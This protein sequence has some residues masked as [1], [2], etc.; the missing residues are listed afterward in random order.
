MSVV[1]W[2]F[3]GSNN[4]LPDVVNGAGI[5]E[6]GF[7]IANTTVSG[8]NPLNEVTNSDMYLLNYAITHCKNLKE[9]ENLLDNWNN[10][11]KNSTVNGNFAVIDSEGGVAMYE[12]YAPSIGAKVEWEKFDANKAV[13]DKG[14][15]LGFV[16][17]TNDNQW[18]PY[19]GGAAREK[20]S[21]E[22][23]K[24][25]LSK[26]QIN[27]KTI[28]RELARDICGDVEKV[29]VAALKASGA[30]ISEEVGNKDIHNFYT[31]T[32]I[33]R[34]NTRFAFIG[35]GIKGK[36]NKQLITM[37]VNLGEPDVGIFTPYFPLSKEV[38]LYAWAAPESTQKKTIDNNSSS[39]MNDLI[40]RK[41][42]LS[43]Y[44][45]LVVKLDPFHIFIIE[46]IDRT[47]DYPKVLEIQNWVFTTE[48]IIITETEKFLD[49]LRQNPKK[50]NNKLLYN[51]SDYAL[52]YGY[53]D[54]NT[55]D[56]PSPV[57]FH[58]W[59]FKY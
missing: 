6:A 56:K 35:R 7:M 31:E 22:I 59:N 3:N 18:S 9:F 43:V 57:E 33:S 53:D 39:M 12:V 42:K 21:N 34:Y 13:D 49:Y 20:R 27:Q 23:L 5:N 55:I 52:R 2:G 46:G 58:E 47:V 17:R 44:D 19:T 11:K 30:D 1:K 24:N 41:G 54:Y 15:L 37:W 48:D 4:F 8:A 40:A 32:C 26:K 36:E 28:M 51:F 14:K 29:D 16:V 10:I 38:A 25:L 45:N 50:I